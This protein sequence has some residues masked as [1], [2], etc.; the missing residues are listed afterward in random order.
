M[1]ENGRH[2]IAI[3]PS[4]P[5]AS[6]VAAGKWLYFGERS[7]LH[8]WAKKLDE[9]I[10]SGQLMSAKIAQK[11]PGVDPVPQK[12]CVVCVYTPKDADA[13]EQARQ[14]I[15][16][17][18]GVELSIWKSEAQTQADWA[19][20]GSLREEYEVTIGQMRDEFG[21]QNLQ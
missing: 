6:Q 12:P 3:V 20:G 19:P 18:F 8:S 5:C 2:W 13:K 21:E 9:L 10:E 1:V 7:E 4:R 15:L 17:E 14:L 16:K 11:T